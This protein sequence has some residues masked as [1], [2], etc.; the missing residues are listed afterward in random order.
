MA[1]KKITEL[2]QTNTVDDS[3]LFIVETANGTC[4]VPYSEIKRLFQNMLE[5]NAGETQS[6][7][8]VD[9]AK[10]FGLITAVFHIYHGLF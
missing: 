5:V 4:S 10:P 8:F 9:C 3:D 7:P 6:F 1:G 2:V